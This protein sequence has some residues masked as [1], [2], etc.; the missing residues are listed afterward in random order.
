M[1]EAVEKSKNTYSFEQNDFFIKKTS[2]RFIM[3]S[4][5]S[6]V[7]IYLGS[8]IDTL[9]IGKFLG[10]NGLSAMSLVSPV[11][12]VFYTV[13]ATIGIGGSIIASRILGQGKIDEYRKVFS[14]VVQLMAIAAIVMIA[15]GYIFMDPI[16]K[17]LCGSVNDG[18]VD[19]V[20]SYL[21]YYI[22]GGALTLMS[23]IPLYFLKI[24][25]K[26]KYSS[27]LFTMS[28]IINVILSWL[29]MSPVFNMGTAGASL[30]TSISYAC[31]AVIGFYVMLRGNTELK[32]V[33]GSIEKKRVR[34]VVVAGVP[35]GVS[36]L[37]ESARIFLLNMLLIYSGASM[38][39]SCY[40]VVRNVNDVMNSVIIGISSALMPLIGIF[41]GERAYSDERMVVNRSMN[42]GIVVMGALTLV[43]CVIPGPIMSLFGVS[44]AATMAEGRWAI[45]LSSLGLVAAYVN[46]QNTSYLTAIKK[47]R[48]ATV[49]VVLRLL[50]MLAVFAFPLSK[51][52]GSMGI[53][54]SLSLTE[55]ATLAVYVLIRNSI[56]K[57]SPN[58]D[59]YLLDTNL[60]VAGD[61]SFA[62]KNDVNDIV[63]AS[64]KISEFCENNDIDMKRAM[65]V[66][67]ALEEILTF[68]TA[69][70]LSD[71]SVNYV[72]VRVCKLDEE[73]MVRFRYVGKIFDPMDY[74]NN[75][76][77][78]EE[79]AEEL[80]GLKMMTNSASLIEFRQTLGTNNLMMVF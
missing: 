48:L 74:Y 1:A 7:F 80:L 19:M 41:Y 25:G 30:A 56:M 60:E 79:L 20:R 32:F 65:K 45:P 51:L 58:I 31:V 69:H 53:W 55:V 62:V 12:L 73:V 59:K 42:L 46:T 39:L 15:G 33:K 6:M 43:M 36:N 49:I 10:E 57:K 22:P 8:L 2:G 34:E 14:C 44:D 17:L 27:R 24:E 61:I 66:S 47:E 68:L 35:N 37:L 3:N 21:M 64:E 18:R 5:I 75:N 9:L 52:W 11:Y 67:L 38:M 13:G 28:A 40:T 29:F 50:V 54:I 23:Y 72:S 78:N 26:P 71:D 77:E 4:V 63:S 16:L 70:C 76:Q